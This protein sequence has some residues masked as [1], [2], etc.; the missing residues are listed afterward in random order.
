MVKKPY[1]VSMCDLL[2]PHF[3]QICKLTECAL[4][5]NAFLLASYR[6]LSAGSEWEVTLM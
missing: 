2:N 5:V 3:T 1:L 4:K 6:C